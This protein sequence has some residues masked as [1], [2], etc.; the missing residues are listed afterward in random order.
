MDL[1]TMA[2]T[3]AALPRNMSISFLTFEFQTEKRMRKDLSTVAATIVAP[4]RKKSITFLTS[5]MRTKK[6][7]YETSTKGLITFLI[8]EI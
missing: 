4:P 8:F 6:R 3:T 2:V 7:N 5:H 1:L